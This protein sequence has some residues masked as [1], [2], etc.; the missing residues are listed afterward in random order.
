MQ[1]RKPCSRGHLTSSDPDLLNHLSQ[2]VVETHKTNGGHCPPSSLHQLLCGLLRHMGEVNPNCPNFLNKKKNVW[3][4]LHSQG[5]GR[6]K[7]AEIVTPDEEEQLWESGI[8]NSTT[9]KALQNA[10]FHLASWES[11]LSSWW[12]WT[13]KSEAIPVWMLWW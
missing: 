1:T 3:F 4:N 2:Y 12:C 7:H 8:V 5:L 10:V 9:P 6:I 13:E 11:I